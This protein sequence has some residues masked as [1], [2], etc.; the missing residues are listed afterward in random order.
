MVK[1]LDRIVLLWDG[2]V[3]AQGSHQELLASCEEYRRLFGG[4]GE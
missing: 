2:T 4:I 3:K 1:D